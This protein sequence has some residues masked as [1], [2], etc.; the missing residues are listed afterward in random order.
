MYA[1]KR[2]SVTSPRPDISILRHSAAAS[3]PSG[4]SRSRRAPSICGRTPR[5]SRSIMYQL[6]KSHSHAAG[7]EVTVP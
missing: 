2:S 1:L 5:Y 3:T 6:S 7:G 4:H